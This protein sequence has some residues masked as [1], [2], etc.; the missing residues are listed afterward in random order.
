M[1]IIATNHSIA[2]GVYEGEGNIKKFVSKTYLPGES[3]EVDDKEADRLIKLGVAKKHDPKT[4][5]ETVKNPTG[6]NK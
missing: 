3:F 5:T 4:D 1:K 2:V 6:G